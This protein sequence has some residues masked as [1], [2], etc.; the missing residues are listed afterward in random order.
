[1]TRLAFICV[2][3]THFD[4]DTLKKRALGGT[5][6]AVVQM[7]KN[8]AKIGFDVSVFNRCDIEDCKPGMYD[9]VWY[10]SLED[11]NE[12]KYF[13]IVISVQSLIPF[14][15]PNYYNRIPPQAY[16]A[17]I[18]D[19]IRT[20]TKWKVVAV[21]N[22]SLGNVEDPLL[23]P[24]LVEGHINEMFTQ[25][26]FQ[27]NY[28]LNCSH[29]GAPKRNFEVLKNKV[30]QTRGGV[31]IYQD[32]LQQTVGTIHTKDPNLFISTASVFKG[33]QNLIY[34]I[35]PKIKERIPDAKLRA[36]GGYYHTKPDDPDPNKTLWEKM[37]PFGSR[38]GV[39]FTGLVGPWAVAQHL[40][41]AS[42]LLAP[43]AYPETFGL[44]L[45][46]AQA[47][48]CPV[49]TCRFGAAEETAVEEACYKINYPIEPNNVYP[50]IDGKAQVAKYVD[51]VVAAHGSFELWTNKAR[52]GN[53]IR[54][55]AGWDGIA[56]QWKQHL[57]KVLNLYFDPGEYFKVKVLNHEV[58]RVFR[59]RW[60]NREE[61]I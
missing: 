9:L 43:S 51:L 48:N 18:F 33:L 38:Y 12:A 30:W 27:T 26:D 45:L 29:H 35:W 22:T 24:L 19:N 53:K 3:G 14:V 11:V 13:D 21:H 2:G 7:A 44:S 37:I 28:L 52:Y 6:A 4:G 50:H 34:D 58:H 20:T 41:K 46:E 56:L 1:M 39:E 42:F 10:H 8:L 32:A 61:M 54:E 15:P 17:S 49:I 23:E 5:E 59:R 36:L 60:M 16:D 47:Y 57:Y 55:I 25:S 31:E 40:Q